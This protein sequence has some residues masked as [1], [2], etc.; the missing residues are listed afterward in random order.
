MR[1]TIHVT[2][3]G[4]TIVSLLSI[5]QRALALAYAT[6]DRKQA[7]KSAFETASAIFLPQSVPRGGP[8]LPQ[9]AV[10]HF[11]MATAQQ[12]PKKIYPAAS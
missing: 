6:L 3:L 5:A 2:V 4:I 10:N 11:F 9:Y 7:L 8:V 12:G 1:H